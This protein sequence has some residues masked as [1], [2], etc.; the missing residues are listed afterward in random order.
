MEVGTSEEFSE[1]M[2]ATQL[3]FEQKSFTDGLVLV[4]PYVLHAVT[5]A[6][7]L[8]GGDQHMAARIVRRWAKTDERLWRE[9]RQ[10]YEARNYKPLGLRYGLLR[11]TGKTTVTELGE[12]P[13]SP[14]AGRCPRCHKEGTQ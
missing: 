4:T 6:M 10:P 8:A 13:R 5:Q 2:R 11:V 1:H 14:F 9:M 12:D 7:A 3:P